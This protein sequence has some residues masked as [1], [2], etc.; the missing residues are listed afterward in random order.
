MAAFARRQ[1]RR[2]H[3]VLGCDMLRWARFHL[4]SGGPDVFPAGVLRQMRE[5]TTAL[6]GSSLGDAIGIGWFLRDVD[7]VRAAGHGGS[8]NGQFADLL[9]VPERGFAVVALCNEGPDGIPFNQAVIRWALQDYLGITDRDPEPLPFHEALARE[10]AGRYENEVM[11]FTVGIDRAD[12]G[13]GQQTAQQTAQ[14]T[15]Q[16]MALRMEVRI[17]PEIRAAADK[18]PPP[19]PAPF[20]VGLLPRHEYIVTGGEYAGQRGFFTRDA[21]GAITGVDLAGRLASRV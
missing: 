10:V 2:G 9:L 6:R 8:A 17:K 21:S 19:D 5:P 16:R 4:G 14:R 12:P 20:E 1:P 11:T 15:G 7:G 18:E 3:R 13:M